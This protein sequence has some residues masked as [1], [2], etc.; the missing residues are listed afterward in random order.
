V[1]RAFAMFGDPLF[2]RAESDGAPVMVVHLGET[3][4]AVPLGA[5]KREFGIEEASDDGRMLELIVQ[6]RPA[7]PSSSPQVAITLSARM[8]APPSRRACSRS[9]SRMTVPF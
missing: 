9:S 2:R 4:A 8:P 3:E 6:A 7:K 5:M 1:H